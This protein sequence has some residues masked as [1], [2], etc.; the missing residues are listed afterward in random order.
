[1]GEKPGM[2]LD[3]HGGIAI[4]IAAERPE[5]VPEENWLPLVRGDYGIDI[6]MR[7][8]RQILTASRPGQRLRLKSWSN[9]NSETA[10]TKRRLPT[11][12]PVIICHQSNKRD[13]H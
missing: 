10:T 9:L 1:M 7:L 12:T 4:H 6:V 8:M 2:K 3:N 5:G 11:R 13:R